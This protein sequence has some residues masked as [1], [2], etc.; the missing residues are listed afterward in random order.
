MGTNTTNIKLENG[1]NLTGIDQ[2]LDSQTDEN[3]K[4]FATLVEKAGGLLSAR[5]GVQGLTPRSLPAGESQSTKTFVVQATNVPLGYYE[6]VIDCK[7]GKKALYGWRYVGFAPFLGCPPNASG[8]H[9]LDCET[10]CLYGL[11][12]RKGVMTFAPLDCISNPNTPGLNDPMENPYDPVVTTTSQFNWSAIRDAE[13]KLR[14]IL[15]GSYQKKIKN[16]LDAKWIQDKNRILVNHKGSPDGLTKSDAEKIRKEAKKQGIRFEIEFDPIPHSDFSSAPD[17]N[18]NPVPH[19][20]NPTGSLSSRKKLEL[21][22]V[23]Q[24]RC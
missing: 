24:T 4:E 7:D 3:I 6:A 20:G 22:T 1:W 16:V 15:D 23:H 8:S 10:E 18:L 13:E 5:E 19:S 2:N 21:A 12:Y 17:G 11:V 9:H 14:R